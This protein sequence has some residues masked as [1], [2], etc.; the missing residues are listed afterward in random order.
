MRTFTAKP[1]EIERKWYIVDA[2]G[3][4]VG[5]LASQVAKIL[6]GKNKPIF[7]PHVDCGDHV[8]IINAEKAIL[9]GRNK[10][11]EKI[12]WHTQFPGGLKCT[13]YS[14]CEHRMAIELQQI[15]EGLPDR[16]FVFDNKDGHGAARPVLVWGLASVGSSNQNRAPAPGLLTTPTCPPSFST[17]RRT[18]D[19]PRP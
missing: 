16:D 5:R 6:R 12:Y 3:M 4:L 14:G 19:R 2:A 15:H 7:T 13:T 11:D 9:T 17:I 18:I 10:P 8:I 1:K